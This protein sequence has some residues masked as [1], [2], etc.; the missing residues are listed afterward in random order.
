MKKI[1]LSLLLTLSAFCLEPVAAI[2]N[3]AKEIIAVVEKLPGATNTEARR[4]EIRKI[5]DPV[6]DFQEMAKRSLGTE[7]NNANDTQKQEFVSV[8]SELLSKTYMSKVETVKKDTVKII[9]SD[10]KE[11]KALVKTSVI[12]NGDSFPLDYKFIKTNDWKVY[13]VI[14]ENIGLVANYRNEFAGIIR[15]DGIDGLISQLKTKLAKLK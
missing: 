10:I 4:V 15:K 8:F 14:I 7:W 12:Y 5:I 9:G 1:F 3:T 13:D 6:F 11:N 2:E